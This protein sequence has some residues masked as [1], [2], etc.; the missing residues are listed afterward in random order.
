VRDP[1]SLP[2]DD[3]D[4]AKKLG[5]RLKKL[6]VAL[7]LKFGDHPLDPEIATLVTKAAKTFAKLGC[8]VEEAAPDLGGVDGGRTFRIHWLCFAQRVLQMFPPEKHS[9][10]DP[11]L[12]AMAREGA[13]YSSADLVAAMADRRT[14]SL[15]WNRFFAKYDLLLCPTLA[16]PPFDTGRMAPELPDGT[17][18]LQWSPYT[19]QFNLSRHP[20][21]S[22]PC[23]LTGSG[24]PVGLMITAAHYRDALVLRAAHRFQQAAPLKLPALPA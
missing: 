20:S 2:A 19:H 10:L 3:A 4:Y 16:V 5:G 14:V 15:G 13:R 9:L 6:K 17:A 24:L 7:M 18:N 23:G 11:T 8:D 22:V 21:A 12:Q 1:L